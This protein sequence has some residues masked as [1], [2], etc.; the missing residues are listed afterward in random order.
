M[1]LV[2]GQTLGT[3]TNSLT[4]RTF[5]QR[6]L[7]RID[8]T[9]L[10]HVGNHLPTKVVQADI[11]ILDKHR[12]NLHHVHRNQSARLKYPEQFCSQ[13]A[14]MGKELR[15]VLAVTHVTVGGVVLE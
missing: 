10:L 14:V 11:A 3:D 4:L 9:V 8:E 12:R 13:E 6:D 15:A 1:E 7:T 2:E 5:R